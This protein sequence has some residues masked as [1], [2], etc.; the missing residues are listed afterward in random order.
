MAL[1]TN[2]ILL[3]AVNY[4]R[5]MF[6]NIGPRRG[7]RKCSYDNLTAFDSIGNKLNNEEISRNLNAF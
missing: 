3:Y 1:S 2:Y 7:I 6:D 4:D 5:K